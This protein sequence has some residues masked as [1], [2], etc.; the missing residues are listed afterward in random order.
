MEYGGHQYYRGRELGNGARII[1]L[2]QRT[3]R[4]GL[5]DYGTGNRNAAE[6]T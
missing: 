2:S 6:G 5:V 3:S 4:N 1:A